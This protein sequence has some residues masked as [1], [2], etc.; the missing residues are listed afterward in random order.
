MVLHWVAYASAPLNHDLVIWLKEYAINIKSGL[1]SNFGKEGWSI[2][3]SYGALVSLHKD[4]SVYDRP[5][6]IV[7]EGYMALALAQ[8]EDLF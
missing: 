7:C 5:G 1:F 4:L 3:L 6:Q 2:G 8:Y